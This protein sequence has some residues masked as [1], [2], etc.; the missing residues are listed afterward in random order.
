MLFWTFRL[1]LLP[2]SAKIK[3][4][5]SNGVLL[6][7]FPWSVIKCVSLRETSVSF[8]YGPQ[9]RQWSSRFLYIISSVMHAFCLVITYDLLEDSCIDDVLIKTFFLN[10]LLYKTNRFQ[11][12][13]LLFNNRSQRTTKCCKRVF[14]IPLPSMKYYVVNFEI[15]FSL[16]LIP[17]C[18]L[19]VVFFSD[20]FRFCDGWR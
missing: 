6:G 13:V 10:S 12:A 4:R 2:S 16:L 18:S 9:K 5:M 15:A 19:S 11:V 20:V 7:P 3:M 14:P 8:W 1:L 17:M